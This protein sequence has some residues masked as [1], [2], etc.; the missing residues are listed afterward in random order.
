MTQKTVCLDISHWQTEPDYSV[1]T[2][3]GILGV[4]LKATEGTSYVDKTFANRFSRGLN[5]GMAMATYH[6]LRHGSI[7]NQMNLYLNTVVPRD[8]ER[9]VLDWEDPAVTADEVRQAVAY[10]QSD[11]RNIQISVYGS[12]SF[13][14]ERV[15]SPQDPIAADTSLWVASYTSASQPSAWGTG[16][17]DWSLWQ[18]T[19][20]CYTAGYGPTDGNRF[21]G[22]AEAFLRWM[23]PSGV[24]MPEAM[25]EPL[26]P[27]VISPDIPTVT[28]TVNSDQKVN[29]VIAVGENVE[30]AGATHRRRFEWGGSYAVKEQGTRAADAGRRALQR[31]REK[32]RRA[33]EGGQGIL[34]GGQGE[35]EAQ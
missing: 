27:A 31:L 17:P 9:M 26:P 23:G 33:D 16:W 6:F 12:S 5:A 7:V 14:R 15:T 11:T 1:L 22:S 29:L 8:G 20:D 19:D 34:E 10:L 25:P 24:E 35:G 13:V 3:A 4:I 2:K 18:W 21:N 32:S 30:F 28:L